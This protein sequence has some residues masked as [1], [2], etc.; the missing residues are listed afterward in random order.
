MTTGERLAFIGLRL[1][2]NAKIIL[3]TP[4]LGDLPWPR[5]TGMILQHQVDQ[6]SRADNNGKHK[7]EGNFPEPDVFI[8]P[9]GDRNHDQA[10]KGKKIP[11]EDP[12]TVYKIP[13]G[14][15]LKDPSFFRRIKIMLN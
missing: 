13:D 7:Q 5:A 14:L 1:L 3:G 8:V 2:T 6:Y 12:E 15:V 11:G 10:G 9:V 4:K